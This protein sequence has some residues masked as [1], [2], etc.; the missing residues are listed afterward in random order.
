MRGSGGYLDSAAVTGLVGLGAG[1]LRDW[2]CAMESA[3]WALRNGLC[4]M[5]SGCRGCEVGGCGNWGVVRFSYT[6]RPPPPVILPGAAVAALRLA[7]ALAPG[8]AV[9]ARAAAGV[10]GGLARC[11]SAQRALAAAGVVWGVAGIGRWL[12]LVTPP[13]HPHP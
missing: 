2:L 10:V 8:F 12:G 13:A 11:A 3:Q 1:G 6:A 7:G 9:P 4:A 5:G